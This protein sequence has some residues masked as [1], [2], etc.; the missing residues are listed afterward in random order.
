MGSQCPLSSHL[1]DDYVAVDHP[2]AYR[3]LTICTNISIQLHQIAETLV[4]RPNPSRNPQ[5]QKD[6]QF[7]AQ[8]MRHHSHLLK[9]N[10]HQAHQQLLV[11]RRGH[12]V[13][14]D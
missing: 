4:Q 10:T 13:H 9:R 12:V 8:R 6:R 3:H 7:D 14:F 5:D 11:T 2:S 1:V